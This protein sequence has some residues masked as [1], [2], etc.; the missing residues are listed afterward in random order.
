MNIQPGAVHARGVEYSIAG[1]AIGDLEVT[2]D[3]VRIR[4][5]G[6][7]RA[8]NGGFGTGGAADIQNTGNGAGV[9]IDDWRLRCFGCRWRPVR[10]WWKES[11]DGM[12]DQNPA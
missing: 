3:E 5:T 9:L 2:K 7:Q 11:G 6:V 4:L 1:V 10:P 8:D 12:R